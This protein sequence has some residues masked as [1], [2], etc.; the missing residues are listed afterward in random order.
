MNNCFSIIF[1]RECEKLEENLA[2]HEKQVSLSLAIM[3]R[4]PII[5]ARAVIIMQNSYIHL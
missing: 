4:N 2:K 3:P 5:T 1:K